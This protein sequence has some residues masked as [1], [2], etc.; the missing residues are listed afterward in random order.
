[1]EP[2]RV[3]HHPR[4]HDEAES[5]VSLKSV[6]EARKLK[7]LSHILTTNM[8][9]HYFVTKEYD[10]VYRR[11]V[12]YDETG[13]ERPR[14]CSLSDAQLFFVLGHQWFRR[15]PS[16]IMCPNC[17]DARRRMQELKKAVTP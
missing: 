15:H 2:L 8:V 10:V 16:V 7:R 1:M 13:E 14:L 3:W 4:S 5:Q 6:W 11:T 12:D 17:I 9:A